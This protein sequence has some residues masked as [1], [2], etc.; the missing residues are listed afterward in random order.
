MAEVR[1]DV[2]ETGGEA[3]SLRRMPTQQ[4]ARER[5]ERI[6]DCAVQLIAR[7][8]SD[9]VRMSEVAKLAGVSIGS[10]Y[11]YFPDKAAII[12]TL[13]ERYNAMGRACI[14]DELSGV[15]HIDALPEAFAG[16]IDI[17]YAMF[18]AE[19]VMRDIWSGTQSDNALREIDLADCRANAAML[20]DTIMRLRPGA[21][22]AAVAD[23]AFLIINLGEA[24]MRLAI[25]LERDEGDR[26][27]A[28]FNRMVRG[29]L[30]RLI[31]T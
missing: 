8:G 17:Y 23:T 20:E 3:T 11:Q 13:A 19:P 1:P 30:E 12:V 9:A 14:R 25:S 10:L 4:R 15:Q 2:P 5:V 26:I 6:L 29:E 31:E 24:A 18:L 7:D 21:D 22:R 16:L 28:A 27:V